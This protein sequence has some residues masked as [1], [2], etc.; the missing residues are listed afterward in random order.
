MEASQSIIA[1]FPERELDIR[2]RCARDAQ[3]L[4]I[5]SDYEEATWA[6]R[7]WKAVA[8]EGDPKAAEYRAFL[9]ELESEILE[10][11]DDR[12]PDPGEA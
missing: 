7:H 1:R 3:F 4:A 10:R 2:R 11:L 8:P 5:C 6:L 12:R 9:E